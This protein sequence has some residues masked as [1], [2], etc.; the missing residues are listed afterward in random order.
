MEEIYGNGNMSRRWEIILPAKEF[1][2]FQNLLFET[3]LDW[4]G[5]KRFAMPPNNVY[6]W[7]LCYPSDEFKV[8]AKLKF[9]IEEPP[10]FGTEIDF[11]G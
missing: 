1:E 6:E 11:S 7:I 9:H 4:Q 8:I 3:D 2:E 5:L 10:I